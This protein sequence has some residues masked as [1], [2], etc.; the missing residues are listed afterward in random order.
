M[1]LTAAI[2][3]LGSNSVRMTIRRL[4]ENGSYEVV[5]NRKTTVRLSE[6]MVCDCLL[7]EAPIGRTIAA[8]KEFKAVTEAHGA[9]RVLAVATAAVR[10]A[11]NGDAF[12]ARVEAE[13]GIR[14]EVLCGADEAY[15]D[16]LGVINTTKLKDGAIVDVGGGSTEIIWVKN[17]ELK[18]A[19]SIPYGAV[20]LTERFSGRPES[21]AYRFFMQQLD[22][23]PWIDELQGHDIYG[24]GGSA[25]VAAMHCVKDYSY[26]SPETVRLQYRS[27]D[28]FYR[29]LLP[30]TPVE[31]GLIPSVTPE[32]GDIIVGGLLPIKALMDMLTSK[33]LYVCPF[34]LREGMFF[35]MKFENGIFKQGRKCFVSKH[36]YNNG[37]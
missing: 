3:D 21:A 2:I 37:I 15:Y 8:L 9:S 28:N 12:L 16:Y 26:D 14:F 33:S 5:D 29:M 18:E 24:I 7:K 22:N 35:R 20:L 36:N 6:G 10:A 1:E 25:R 32:R 30:L 27:L 4:F 17:R 13:T 23:I 11:K 31:R 34:G 19:V